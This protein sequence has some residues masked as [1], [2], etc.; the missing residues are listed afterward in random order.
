[1]KTMIAE[2]TETRR[3][4]M[5]A[6]VEATAGPYVALRTNGG[7]WAVFVPPLMY[8]VL[9]ATA[10]TTINCEANARLLAASWVMR[11]ALRFALESGDEVE[12]ERRCRAALEAAEGRE[13]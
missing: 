9:D 10:P 8:N 6:P 4:P 5:S 3:G 2:T 13:R 12:A 7:G 11:E 1:M